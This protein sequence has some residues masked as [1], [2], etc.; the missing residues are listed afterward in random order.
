VDADG[1]DAGLRWI[2]LN[3]DGHADLLFAD[4]TRFSIDLFDPELGIG[5]R[6]VRSGRQPAQNNVPPIVRGDGNNGVWFARGHLWVQN[7]DTD[8]LN[9]GIDRRSFVQ[10][11]HDASTD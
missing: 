3:E 5:W 10:L 9:D 6:R 11:L 2:D 1:R 7:E 4:A 8:Q